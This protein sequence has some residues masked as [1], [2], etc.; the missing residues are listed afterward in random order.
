M[1]PR[2]A[3]CA[4]CCGDLACAVLL[5]RHAASLTPATV[6]LRCLLVLSHD[7]ALR[8]QLSL[9]VR[10]APDLFSVLALL[11][12]LAGPQKGASTV[13]VSTL[14]SFEPDHM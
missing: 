7:R 3:L 1:L 8:T 5:G 13:N 6:V 12:C 4:A 11:A 9:V 10:V 14:E 2:S